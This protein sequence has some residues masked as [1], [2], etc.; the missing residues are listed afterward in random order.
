MC[1]DCKLALSSGGS[2][3]VL[4]AVDSCPHSMEESLLVVSCV[5]MS[6]DI[7][8]QVCCKH[9]AQWQHGDKS[10]DKCLWAFLKTARRSPEVLNLCCAAVLQC[11]SVLGTLRTCLHPPQT[12]M[13]RHVMQQT[14]SYLRDKVRLESCIFYTITGAGVNKSKLVSAEPS[15]Y[16]A[17]YFK[18]LQSVNPSTCAVIPPAQTVSK[19]Y[20]QVPVNPSCNWR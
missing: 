3:H 7:S 15:L 12:S 19:Q 5:M 17:H 11:P 8:F 16:L 9:H 14:C 13:E 4:R 10:L 6:V 18:G 20:G 2:D 1:T